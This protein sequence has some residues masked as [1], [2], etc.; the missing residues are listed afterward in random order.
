MTG[1]DLLTAM[2]GIDGRYIEEAAPA[3]APKRRSLR[4]PLLVAAAIAAALL[5]VGC[6]REFL[7]TGAVFGHI[8]IHKALLPMAALPAGGFVLLGVLAAGW[9]AA[10]NLY[11]DFKHEE[12]RRLY[13]NR[14]Y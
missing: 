3:A 14:K 7:A 5:L 9:L 6:L 13:A 1:K 11:N 4:R 2:S 12:V 10:V 8:V